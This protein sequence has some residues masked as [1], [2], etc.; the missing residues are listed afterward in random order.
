MILLYG[1]VL[2]AGIA[3]AI[4]PGQTTQLAK[5]LGQPFTAGLVSMFVG[6][7][8]MFAVGLL[9]GHLSVPSLQQAG[10]A[11]W[12]AWLGGLVGVGL[13][14]AQLFVAQRIGA[15][16][17]LGL[18]VTAGVVTSIALDHFGLVGFDVHAAGP[19]RLFGGALMIAGVTFVALS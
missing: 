2:I 3:N 14:I 18:L 11:P 17:F 12:W 8:G 15:A 7:L 5:A 1:A 10:Q 19:M 4:Q 13:L 6:T 16:P 9:S